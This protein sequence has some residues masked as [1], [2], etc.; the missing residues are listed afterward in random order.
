MQ[1]DDIYIKK[2]PVHARAWVFH[3]D[4]NGYQY[5]GYFDNFVTFVQAFRE[6]VAFFALKAGKLNG[7]QA[8]EA[9]TRP[10]R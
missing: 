6:C 5:S 7:A 9:L 3:V 2:S 1:I 10:V 8:A 4:M